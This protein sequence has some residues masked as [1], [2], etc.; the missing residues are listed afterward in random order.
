MSWNF[1]VPTF[2]IV[3]FQIFEHIGTFPRNGVWCFASSGSNVFRK[4]FS[5]FLVFLKYLCITSG[6]QSPGICKF[7]NIQK[8]VS[9][10]LTSKWRSRKRCETYLPQFSA[11]IFS[12]CSNSLPNV[13]LI[14]ADSVAYFLP[15]FHAM[16]SDFADART[17]F[18]E[19]TAF[20]EGANPYHERVCT[21]LRNSKDGP[22][23]VLGLYRSSIGA[24]ETNCCTFFC[25]FLA[26]FLLINSLN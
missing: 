17:W 15:I 2:H 9:H 22:D 3:N 25:K 16:E 1:K 24:R 18:M 6:I 8:C 26:L 7:P 4:W 23:N 20:L 10:M 13:Y 12:K 5:T 21:G 11:R 14:C 19:I